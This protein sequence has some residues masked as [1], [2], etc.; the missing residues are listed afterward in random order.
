MEDNALGRTVETHGH[1]IMPG[2]EPVRAQVLQHDD[3]V[4]RSHFVQQFTRPFDDVGQTGVAAGGGD[5]SG[6]QA[7]P[8]VREVDLADKVFQRHG[9]TGPGQHHGHGRRSALI[10]FLGNEGNVVNDHPVGKPVGFTQK[11]AVAAVGAAAGRQCGHE[12]HQGQSQAV[13][14][15]GQVQAHL[16]G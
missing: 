16:S 2:R 3:R 8:A 14:R 15:S 11:P 4:T 10:A 1:R 7:A 6:L 12:Q 13:S 5:Q 9:G